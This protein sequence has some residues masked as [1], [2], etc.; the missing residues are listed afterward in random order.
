MANAAVAGIA[1]WPRGDADGRDG[2]AVDQ[3]VGPESVKRSPMEAPALLFLV[4]GEEVGE[5]IGGIERDAALL[6][7][8]EGRRRR[9][10][11]DE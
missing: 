9:R 1:R 7:V 10:R 2:N 8:A 5:E 11:R 4:V 3:A 6:L